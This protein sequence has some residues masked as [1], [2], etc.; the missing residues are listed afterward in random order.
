MSPAT[1]G[2]MV[3]L[4]KVRARGAAP[5]SAELNQPYSLQQSEVTLPTCRFRSI[6]IHPLPCAQP[7]TPLPPPLLPGSAHCRSVRRG[8]QT[9]LPPP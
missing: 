2:W 6:H 5:G 7:P 8:M 9:P 3:D 4:S 1:E